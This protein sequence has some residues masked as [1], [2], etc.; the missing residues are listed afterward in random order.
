[1]NNI[2][3]MNKYIIERRDGD[4]LKFR[5]YILMLQVALNYYEHATGFVLSKQCEKIFTFETFKKKLKYLLNLKRP[6]N[7]EAER[8]YRYEQIHHYL[9]NKF[10]Y[11]FSNLQKLKKLREIHVVRGKN[12][13]PIEEKIHSINILIYFYMKYL[14]DESK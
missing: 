8:D 5:K 6:F 2:V 10:E 1:M 9:N 4:I 3:D 13:L 14:L 7:T 12:I 11:I